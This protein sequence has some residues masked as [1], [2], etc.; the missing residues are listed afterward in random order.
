MVL[1]NISP[2]VVDSTAEGSGPDVNVTPL[3]Y[4]S[5]RAWTV[6][7][8][9]NLSN[10]YAIQPP[11]EDMT[12]SYPL[13]LLAEGTF[14]SYFTN[15]PVPKPPAS[16]SESAE[17]DSE[18]NVISSDALSVR[19]EVQTEGRGRIFVMGSSAVLGSNV[20]D[21][22]GNTG[23]SLFV[24]NLLDHMNDRTDYAVMRTKGMSYS[25]LKETVPAVRSFIKTFNIAGL[26]VIVAAIG[27]AV[28]LMRVSRKRRIQAHFEKYTPG[29]ESAEA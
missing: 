15:R 29:E 19:E 7:E 17:A 16:E 2:F 23:N 22:E 18:A 10:P 27:L 3:M 21:A 26:A 6:S 11:P 14:R 9:I 28:W 13:A 25:P 12:E 20:L 8:N 4:S 5:D 1:L 24:L